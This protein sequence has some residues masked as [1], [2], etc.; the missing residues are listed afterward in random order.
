MAETFLAAGNPL[1]GC[2]GKEL[3]DLHLSAFDCVPYW[4]TVCVGYSYNNRIGA[5]GCHRVE[6][7]VQFVAHKFA[8]LP[9]AGGPYA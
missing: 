3:A 9:C 4:L 6:V 5:S 2:Q 7:D 8:R 1:S